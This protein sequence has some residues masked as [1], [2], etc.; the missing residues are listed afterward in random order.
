MAVGDRIFI[1]LG[2]VTNHQNGICKYGPVLRY[3]TTMCLKCKDTSV[4]RKK[5]GM[6]QRLGPSMTGLHVGMRRKI[7]IC[8]IMIG[9]TMGQAFAG[10]FLR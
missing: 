9:G 6:A 5:T 1:F 4:G 10:I 7:H 2:S 8:Y 3:Q